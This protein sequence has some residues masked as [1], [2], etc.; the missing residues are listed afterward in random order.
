MRD[1]LQLLASGSAQGLT[2]GLIAI[3]FVSV[4]SVSR[5]IN[6]AQGQFAAIAGLLGITLTRHAVPVLAAC[7]V[8]IAATTVLALVLERIVI[9]P[10]YGAPPVR[11]IVLTLGVL[12]SLEGATLLIWGPDS[13]G[14][15]AFTSGNV[16][17]GGVVVPAQDIWIGAV[18]ALVAA[19]LWIFATR[20]RA[21]K[22]FRACAEQPVAARLVGISPSHVYRIGFALAGAVGA[23]GGLVISPVQLTSWDTGLTLGLKGFVAASLA[24]LVSVPGA[25][26]GGLAV[27]VAESL[28]AGYISSG[29]ADATAYLA[30][31]VVLMLRPQGL[32]RASKERV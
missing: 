6:I 9:A 21:G 11:H 12:I 27:G 14:L 3:G 16:S 13:A 8:A 24:G 22:A 7:V 31:I 2:Y 30:L 4:Y 19:S 29:T 25:L 28:A 15:P 23:I 1:L 18:T 17:A 10:T 32:V 5:V 26:V 20:T